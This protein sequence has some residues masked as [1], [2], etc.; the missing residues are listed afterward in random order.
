MI[1]RNSYDDL[2]TDYLEEEMES[3]FLSLMSVVIAFVAVAVFIALAWY[4]YQAGTDVVP[5]EEVEV[6]YPDEG[7]IR[8]EPQEPGGWQFPNQNKTVYNILSGK[9]DDIKVE[10]ILPTPEQ[11]INRSELQTQT[12][13]NNKIV[14]QPIAKTDAE[15]QMEAKRKNMQNTKASLTSNNSNTTGDNKP[16]TSN[17]AQTNITAVNTNK[18]ENGKIAGPN[19]A[20]NSASSSI[21]NQ[22]INKNATSNAKANNNISKIT[23]GTAIKEETHANN[24]YADQATSPLTKIR[25][26]LG[27]YRTHKEAKASWSK[28]RKQHPDLVKNKALHIE[29]ADISGKGTFFRVQIYPF[30]TKQEASKLCKQLSAKGQACFTVIK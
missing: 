19:I 8:E 10:K 25:L 13:I 29:R 6:V 22:S 27:A 18:A 5:M 2:E 12:W 14:Q 23:N 16:L 7:A 4:A 24:N 26:Q 9:K 20:S 17:N 3:G 11:P 28:L 15:R 30:A 21:N 1:D